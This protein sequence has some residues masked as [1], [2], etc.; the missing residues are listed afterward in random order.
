MKIIDNF[1]N[2]GEYITE[3]FPKKQIYLHHTV[4]SSDSVEGDI[5]WWNENKDRVATAY[6]I[7]GDGVIYRVFDDKFWAHHLGLKLENN[8]VLNRGSIGIELD[9]AGQLR[10]D[11]GQYISSFGRVIPSDK[12]QYYQKPFRGFNYFEKYSNAQIAALK[13]LLL[14]LNKRYN[15]PLK[16]N[17]D[18]WD[19]SQN[20]LKGN[21]GVYTHVSVRKDKSDCH[22]Q[23]ELIEMLKTL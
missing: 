2:K 9:N 11:K 8:T 16:Y 1:L 10:Y 23:P 22:P 13:E 17:E 5:S 18:M 7:R 12:V 4:S 20:A 14:D 3:V 6:I 19:I 21:T 15:I